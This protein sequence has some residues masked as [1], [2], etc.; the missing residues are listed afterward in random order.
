MPK[1]WAVRLSITNQQEDEENSVNE[2]K[3]KQV[4]REKEN[5]EPGVLEAK[6]KGCFKVRKQSAKSSTTST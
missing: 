1:K 4:T 5:K 2:T 6:G 3:K